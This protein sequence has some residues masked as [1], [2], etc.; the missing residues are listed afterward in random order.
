MEIVSEPSALSWATSLKRNRGKMVAFLIW[1]RSTTQG[2][3]KTTRNCHN[4]R[5]P[6]SGGKRVVED[7][8]QKRWRAHNSNENEREMGNA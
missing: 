1:P 4:C 6:F 2:S 8:F 7:T 3:L 5:G